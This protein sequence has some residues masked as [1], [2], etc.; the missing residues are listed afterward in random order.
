MLQVPLL[1]GADAFQYCTARHHLLIAI[2]LLH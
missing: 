1:H 2:A